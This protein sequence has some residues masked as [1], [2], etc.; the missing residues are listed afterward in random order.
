[1]QMRAV[2]N[3]TL[4][5]K[6]NSDLIGLQLDDASVPSEFNEAVQNTQVQ[7][8]QIISAQN[9]KQS[10]QVELDSM[11]NNAREL[12]KVRINQ[13]LA[14][15]DADVKKNQAEMESFLNIITSQATAYNVLKTG[16]NMT[17]NQLIQ[18][19]KSQAINNYNQHNMVIS[20]PTRS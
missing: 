19:I 11:A 16:L 10:T 5:T 15:A 1:M 14:A 7:E 20:L 3:D 9:K 6:C 17:N 4:L 13:A 18:Y 12:T 8:S 2:A